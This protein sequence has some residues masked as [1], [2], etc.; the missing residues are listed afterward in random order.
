M[1]EY[2]I[3]EVITISYLS[4][5]VPGESALVCNIEK[6]DIRR[7]LSE[8]GLVDKTRVSCVAKSALGGPSAY[9]IRGAL[10]ALRRED[11]RAVTV[12]STAYGEKKWD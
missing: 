7:R 4:E 10:V 1:R 8:L 5:L 12:E 9:L 2:N 6:S 11:A 3:S